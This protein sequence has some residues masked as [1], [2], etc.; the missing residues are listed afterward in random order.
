MMTGPA[1][2]VGCRRGSTAA[3]IE[4]LIHEALALAP[5]VQPVGVFTIA[6][7]AG[8][9][10][11]VEAVHRLAFDLVF[12]SRAVLRDQQASIRTRSSHAERRFG[13]PSVAEAAALAG[14]G[15]HSVLIVERLA[16]DGVTCAIAGPSGGSR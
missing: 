16:R 11:L 9:P 4:S 7:K 12:L 2:G 10:G 1:I 14:A 15:P 8:E 5:C 13:V 3:A 6:D